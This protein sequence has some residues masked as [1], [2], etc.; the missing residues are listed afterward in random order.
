MSAAPPV[1]APRGEAPAGPVPPVDAMLWDLTCGG[2]PLGGPPPRGDA[3]CTVPQEDDDERLEKNGCAPASALCTLYPTYA[4]PCCA[5]DRDSA[6]A[7][8]KRVVRNQ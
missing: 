8:S 5:A 1:L 3:P 7:S 6:A 2:A 4:V